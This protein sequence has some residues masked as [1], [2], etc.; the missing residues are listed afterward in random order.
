MTVTSCTPLNSLFKYI[1]YGPNN[2]L[3]QNVQAGNKTTFENLVPG[4]YTVKV[5]SLSEGFTSCSDEIMIEIKKSTLKVVVEKE[6]ITCYGS[7]DGSATAQV[8]GG[9]GPYTYKWYNLSADPQKVISELATVTGLAA[10]N[11]YRVTVTDE[12]S[13]KLIPVKEDITLQILHL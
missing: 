7:A 13:C 11:K 4:K 8:T 10:G 2:N 12:G 9:L 3:L 1:L 6:D 5:S